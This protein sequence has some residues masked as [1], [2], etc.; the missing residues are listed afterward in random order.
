VAAEARGTTDDEEQKGERTM[1]MEQEAVERE[2]P[3]QELVGLPEE[4]P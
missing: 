3:E 2:A 1:Q 4:H